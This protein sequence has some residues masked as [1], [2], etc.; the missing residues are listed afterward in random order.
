MD[1][2]EAVSMVRGW[3]QWQG[4]RWGKAAWAEGTAGTKAGRCALVWSIPGSLDPDGL[5]VRKKRLQGI[6]TLNKCDF[7]FI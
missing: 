4:T 7:W 6:P 5:C 3:G 1:M 2:T